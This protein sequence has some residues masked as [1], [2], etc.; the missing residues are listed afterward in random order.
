MSVIIYGTILFVS[1][2]GMLFIPLRR[3][4][5]L[6]AADDSDTLETTETSVVRTYVLGRIDWAEHLY[7][8]RAKEQFLKLLDRVLRIFERSAGRV[9]GE[10]K[11]VRMM[12]QERFRVIPR[13]SLY[14][15]QIHAWKKTNGNGNGAQKNVSGHE[16]DIS[17]HL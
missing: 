11:H 1:V 17:N 9:A 6:R 4:P 8:I 5:R 10:T 15:K 12:I 14:W 2:I 7:R 3:L 13:E 16:G